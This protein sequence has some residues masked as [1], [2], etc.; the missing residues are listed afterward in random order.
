MMTILRSLLFVPGNT[1]RMLDRAIGLRPDAFVPDMEDSVPWDEKANARGV[2]AAY[3][4]ELAATGVPVIPRVNSLD[5]GLLEDDLSAVAGPYVYG[6]SVGKMDNP[7]IVAEVARL[8]DRAES[9][10]GVESGAIRLVPWIESAEAIVKVY[11][12]CKSSD[13]IVA[14]ALGAE[15]FTNDM[16]IK[17]TDGDSELAYARG[18]IAVAARAAGVLALDTPFFAFRDPV[19]LKANSEMSRAIGFKGR[20]AIHPAQLDIINGVYSPS[21]DEVAQARREI[22]AFEEAVAMGR[23]STSLDGKVIDVPVVKRAHALLDRAKAMGLTV[24][25]SE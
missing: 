20:F 17:R 14:V 25:D 19:A 7:E 21:E 16:E 5:T 23:G 12:I 13:R 2:T 18:A 4:P 11:D 6:V 24:A 15:D 9:K 8:L 3:I 10:A 1:P 22:E